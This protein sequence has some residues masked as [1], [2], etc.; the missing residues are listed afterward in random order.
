M[1]RPHKIHVVVG[2]KPK[3]LPTDPDP[4]KLV[5]TI[6]ACQAAELGATVCCVQSFSSVDEQPV[7]EEMGKKGAA[8]RA[9][10]LRGGHPH[11]YVV[12]IENYIHRNR[13]GE[14]EDLAAIVVMA[15][16]GFTY[17]WA[18]LP[19]Q[20]DAMDVLA[21][22]TEGFDRTTVGSMV[23]RRLGCK[24]DDPHGPM[25]GH[26]RSRRG[27]LT[28]ALTH[29]FRQV[30]A[31]LDESLLD[32]TNGEEDFHEVKAGRHIVRLPWGVAVTK[33]GVR[34]R[35]AFFDLFGAPAFKRK[36]NTLLARALAPYI[37]EDVALVITPEGKGVIAGEA[38]A[39]ALNI[40]PVMF[41][42]KNRPMRPA[43]RKMRYK[44]VTTEEEQ[45]LFLDA[46]VLSTLEAN[47]GKKVVI[48]DDVVTTAGTVGAIERLVAE[49]DMT[50]V[51]AFI[52][53][54]GDEWK[55]HIDPARVVSLNTLP[56][57]VPLED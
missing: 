51:Y 37:P 22:K 16:D 15:P 38:L 11:A 52:F 47:R 48:F 19:I 6:D 5:A 4:I 13:D 44:S 24:A 30:K 10:V 33:T 20:L 55:E 21:A 50:V 9:R 39:G 2:T 7:G 27:L 29:V 26:A 57:P 18:S 41:R 56:A 28:K 1:N 45:D 35:L 31:D 32:L 17:T 8:N 54:E 36:A 34:L 12:G 23:A 43:K 40:D 3:K 14:W 53:T 49:Y 42:K 25:S 46:D